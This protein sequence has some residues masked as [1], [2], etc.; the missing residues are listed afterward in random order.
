MSSKEAILARLD[1]SA[2][3]RLCVFD[4]HAGYSRTARECEVFVG[5]KRHSTEIACMNRVPSLMIEYRPKCRNFMANLDLEDFFIRADEFDADGAIAMLD[6][7]LGDRRG[8]LKKLERRIRHHK[9][10]QIEI[11]DAVREFFLYSSDSDTG[12]AAGTPQA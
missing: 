8:I 12:L 10:V 4:S 6:R 5:Q 11:A 3:K 1:R 7:L 9:K 2:C